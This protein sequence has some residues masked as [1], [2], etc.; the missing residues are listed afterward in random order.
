MFLLIWYLHLPHMPGDEQMGHFIHP[1][2]RHLKKKKSSGLKN[3]LLRLSS[4]AVLQRPLNLSGSFSLVVHNRCKRAVK[5]FRLYEVRWAVG[6]PFFKAGGST[7]SWLVGRPDLNPFSQA[8]GADRRHLVC[9]SSPSSPRTEA[10]APSL[11]TYQK[12]FQ[13]WQ[14][15]VRLSYAVL[16]I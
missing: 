6:S 8:G 15:L 14:P 16:K 2:R 11:R 9:N 5:D 3:R 4:S 13:G 10:F 12:G 7:H 1:H